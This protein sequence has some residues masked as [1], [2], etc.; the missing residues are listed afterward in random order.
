[1]MIT[2]STHNFLRDWRQKY[3]PKRKI[4]KEGNSAQKSQ[5]SLLTILNTELLAQWQTTQKWNKESTIPTCSA[6]QKNL[7]T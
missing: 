6:K 1:M 3:R 7:R 4:G 5:I 2:W